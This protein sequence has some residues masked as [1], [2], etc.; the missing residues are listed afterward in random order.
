[1][2]KVI[3]FPS[4]YVNEMIGKAVIGIDGPG[5]GENNPARTG[6]IIAET[7]NFFG[8]FWEVRWDNGS[9]DFYSKR[10]IKHVT[11]LYGIGVY[12]Q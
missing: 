12:Y 6:I 3:K 8:D 10:T 9:Q 1:M 7:S 11:E 2:T 5:Q 4:K